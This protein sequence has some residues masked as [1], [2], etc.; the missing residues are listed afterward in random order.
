MP[1]LLNSSHALLWD[2]IE[3]I[4]PSKKGDSVSRLWSIR[5]EALWNGKFFQLLHLL[6]IFLLKR[7]LLS[8]LL[9]TIRFHWIQPKPLLF[10]VFLKM[11][12]S[13][14]V[15]PG[16]NWMSPSSKMQTQKMSYNYLFHFLTRHKSDKKISFTNLKYV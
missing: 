16:F 6:H 10:N 2:E 7:A 5:K 11:K 13:S 4:L 12:H 15:G 3:R 14:K 8:R 9:C 1:F